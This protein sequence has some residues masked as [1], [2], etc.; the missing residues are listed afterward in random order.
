MSE[1]ANVI[2]RYAQ[3]NVAEI[4]QQWD[5]SRIEGDAEISLDTLQRQAPVCP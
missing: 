5:G 2:N 1:V 3:K 4:E